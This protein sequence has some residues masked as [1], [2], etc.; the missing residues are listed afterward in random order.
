MHRANG[1]LKTFLIMD[2][3]LIGCLAGFYMHDHQIN[4]LKQVQNWGRFLTDSAQKAALAAGF[5]RPAQKV[6]PLE[7][8]QISQN[9]E[10][11]RG[12][13]VTAL[14]MLLAQA[15]ISVDKMTLANSIQKVSYFQ[16][17]YYGNPNEGFVGSMTDKAQPGFGVYHTPLVRLAQSFLPHRIIDMTGQSFTDVER[18]LS[19]GKAV[20]I[21]TNITFKPLAPDLF[22]NWQTSSGKVK[23]TYYEH[24]VLLTGYNKTQVFFNNPL[25]EKN[26]AADK[27][28]FV[29]A[30]QQMG[31]QAISYG[32]MPVH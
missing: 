16:N 2:L 8:P 13:E 21:I 32:D 27:A 3:L 10:L 28:A 22:Q 14:A 15:G 25:G 24:T 5:S 18:Q 31:S 26:Q 30:W 7:A 12:C 17:G 29:Q 4:P 9:P 23:I 19:R 1:P 6:A 20:L 11:P